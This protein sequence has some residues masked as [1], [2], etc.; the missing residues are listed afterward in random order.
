MKGFLLNCRGLGDL[1][2][3]NYLSQISR[4]HRLDFIALTET[5]HSSFSDSALRH[6]YGGVDFLWRIM[7]PRGRSGGL[8]LGVNLGVYD[9]GAI[10]EGEFFFVSS[11]FKINMIA[12]FGHYLL[13]MV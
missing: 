4:E 12:S 5:G 13:F 7:P 1:A 10:D 3:H 11:A 2:K 8:M 6:F 9:I